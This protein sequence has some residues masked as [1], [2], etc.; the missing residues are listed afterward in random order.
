MVVRHESI[1]IAER[2][3]AH[4][5]FGDSGLSS[6]PGQSLRAQR[7]SAAPDS[8]DVRVRGSVDFGAGTGTGAALLVTLASLP[9]RGAMR[10][11]RARAAVAR[12][13]EQRRIGKRRL[14]RTRRMRMQ[15]S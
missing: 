3:S 11:T 15:H 9:R 7:G 8:A 10:A 13:D 5:F 4:A 14:H 12:D 2:R 6:T 1:S